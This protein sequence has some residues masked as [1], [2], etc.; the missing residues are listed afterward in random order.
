MMNKVIIDRS[1]QENRASRNSPP[2]DPIRFYPA[3][4]KQKTR[5]GKM[6]KIYQAE[7]NGIKLDR[8]KQMRL[9]EE[10]R[11][12]QPPLVDQSKPPLIAED[13]ERKLEVASPRPGTSQLEMTDAMIPKHLY[14]GRKPPAIQVSK[15]R[16]RYSGNPADLICI[17]GK[18]SSPKAEDMSEHLMEDGPGQENLAE[19]SGNGAIEMEFCQQ[20]PFAPDD[21]EV[22]IVAEIS[23]LKKQEKKPGHRIHGPP[24]SLVTPCNQ[25]DSRSEQSSR[26]LSVE[27][28]MCIID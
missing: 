2:L 25:V 14:I 16:M 12:G 27:M 24:R 4:M 9:K 26:I 8:I 23:G 20:Q 15:L 6:R 18:Q 19:P 21:D 13:P 5:I 3:P 28:K 1:S 17:S 22:I 7:L 10:K 11:L